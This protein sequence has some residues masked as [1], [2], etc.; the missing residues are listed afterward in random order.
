[1]KIIQ[2]LT[3]VLCVAS[4]TAQ[5][6]I[7]YPVIAAGPA[8]ID[9]FVPK[10]WHIL[11]QVNGDLN[12]DGLPD[13][14]VVVEQNSTR[15]ATEKEMSGPEGLPRVLF[16]LFQTSDKKYQK[17]AQSNTICLMSDQGGVMGDPYQAPEIAKGV[18]VVRMQG[19]SREMWHLTYRF[20]FQNGDFFLIGATN[21]AVDRGTGKSQTYDLN[22]ST[23]SLE[24]YATN[25]NGKRTATKVEKVKLGA[26]PK[27]ST[28]VPW[29]LRIREGIEF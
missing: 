15:T 24:S 1:M 7:K 25:M 21:D 14:V 12:K 26:L 5:N 10:G 19:G 29:G 9:A 23:K 27:L 8:K 18:L 22:L 28:F 20:R 6:D 2:S 3:L 11:D 4:A 13:A 17:A 16:V